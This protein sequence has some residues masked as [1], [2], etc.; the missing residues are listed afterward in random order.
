MSGYFITNYT[1]HDQEK[2]ANYPPVVGPTIQQY[3]GKLLV[4]DRDAKVRGCPHPV[5]V[6]IEFE[7]VEVVQRWYDSPEY[8]AIKH[9]RID[10]TEGWEAIMPAFVPPAG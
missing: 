3:G 1:V 10:A 9:Y 6:I 4:R 8:T 7:S 5:L 2:F